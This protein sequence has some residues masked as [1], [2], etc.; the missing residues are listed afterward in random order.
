MIAARGAHL[1]N[2][3]RP[4]LKALAILLAFDMAVAVAY[5]VLDWKWLAFPHIPLTIFGGVIGVI[6]GFRNNSSYA[7]WWEGRT[8]WGAIVNNSRSVAR[9]ALTLIRAENPADEDAVRELQRAL[10]YKQIA[11]VY[12]LRSSLRALDPFEPIAGF[13]SA[14]EMARV[15][16]QKNVATAVQQE[17]ASDLKTAFDRGWLDT[18][19]WSAL[20]QTLT[21]L[22]NAQGGIERIKNTPM[23]KQYDFFPQLFVTVYTFLLPLAMV[24]NLQWFTPL[25]S[26]LIGV[27]FLALD[28]IGRDLEEPFENKPNDIAMTAICRTIEINLRQLLGESKVPDPEKPVNGVL[29]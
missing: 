10:V 4:T 27:I 6:V 1:Y 11:Y 20:D 29:W 2:L 5:M 26:A 17:M 16:R 22:A 19:R 13:L 7:R 3:F 25:G 21:A 24:Q 12:G 8:L 23:P 15:R 9:Q 18:I 14:E 28:Q